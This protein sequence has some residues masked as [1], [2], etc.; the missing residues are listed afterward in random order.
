[1]A[2]VV[3]SRSAG[4]VSSRSA[5]LR[6]RVV[7]R[8]RWARVV[9][10]RVRVRA[11]GG[12]DFDVSPG[13]FPDPS[14]DLTQF[15]ESQ[16]SGVADALFAGDTLGVDSDLVTGELRW[17]SRSTLKHLDAS[18]LLPPERFAQAVAVHV[19]RNFFASSSTSTNRVPLVL[20]IWGHK[21]VGKSLNVELTL[22]RMGVEP[23]IMSAGEMEDGVAGVPAERIRNRYR[24]AARSIM[25]RGIASCLVIND[26][27]AGLGRLKFTDGTVNNQNATATLMALCDDPGC[28]SLG[29]SWDEVKAGGRL[30][31]VPIIVTANDLS[32]L[33]APLVRDGRME[34]FLWEPTNDELVEMLYP[35]LGGT[36]SHI[37]R[38]DIARLVSRHPNQPLDFFM[39]ARSRALDG[40]LREWLG[41]LR[42]PAS[43][44]EHRAHFKVD[45]ELDMASL[46]E[47]MDDL[48][49]EQ[50][51]ILNENLSR[52]YLANWDNGDEPSPSPLP[53][54]PPPPP[55]AAAASEELRK[56]AV[57]AL[58]SAMGGDFF[59]RVNVVSS[60]DADSPSTQPDERVAE[61]EGASQPEDDL[62]LPWRSVSAEDAKEMVDSGAAVLVDLRSAKNFDDER[63]RGSKN[64]PSLE[65]QGTSF[66]DRREVAIDPSDFAASFVAACPPAGDA[67]YVIVAKVDDVTTDALMAAASEGAYAPENILV[68]SGGYD[69]WTTVFN[70]STGKRRQVGHFVSPG[71][72]GRQQGDNPTAYQMWSK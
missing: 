41:T 32:T 40:I 48:A 69:G 51:N 16:K 43:I 21:G 10:R 46:A 34:K 23:V 62:T 26:I 44:L 19:A 35:A 28:V 60:D 17:T 9:T 3:G 39:A 29:Q 55:P 5:C 14:L 64:V 50:Q 61:V 36:K 6:L 22:A 25:H 13:G 63:I 33:Y 52:E 57:D 15:V 24:T 1:M 72:D 70:P 67:T 56:A 71:T 38:D 58:Q 37:T 18:R 8:V 20:G 47:A 4:L 11:S 59:E 2:P 30:P 45:D 31:R 27:D 53:P 68:V 65:V 49:R 42:S 7:P 66:R 54:P 12:G